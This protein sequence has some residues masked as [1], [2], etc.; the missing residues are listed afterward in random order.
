M[1]SDFK[2]FPIMFLKQ[3]N[4]GILSI[5]QP[6]YVYYKEKTPIF[7]NLYFLLLLSEKWLGPKSCLA[8]CCLKANSL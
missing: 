8:I 1:I 6:F 3:L 7:L 4:C 5:K 2:I